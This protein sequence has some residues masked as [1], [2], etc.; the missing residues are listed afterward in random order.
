MVLPAATDV[1]SSLAWGNGLQDSLAGDSVRVH[2]KL[3]D[4][5]NNDRAVGGE[6]GSISFA[7][8]RAQ[9]LSTTWERR[10]DIVPETF[11]VRDNNDG[12]YTISYL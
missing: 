8:N 2:I 1:L 5:Y 4:R 3:R 10:P 7:Y 12:T 6:L 9:P 11:D